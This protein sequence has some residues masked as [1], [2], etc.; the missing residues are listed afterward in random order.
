ME[1]VSTEANFAPLPKRPGKT[2]RPVRKAQALA[3]VLALVSL[4][5]PACNKHEEPEETNTHKIVTTS[6]AAKDVVLTQEYVCQIHSRRHIKIQALQGGYLQ[7]VR[8]KEGQVVKEGDL[9]FKIVPVLYKASLD[10][11]VAEAK[12]AELELKNTERLFA[13]K[14]VSKNEVLLYQA[15]VAKAQAKVAKARAELNFTDVKAPFDGIV[16]RLHDF[17]GSL[18]K[19]GDILTTLSDNGQMWVYF[20]VPEARYLDYMAGQGEGKQSPDIGLMLANGSKYPYSGKITNTGAKFNNE[21]GNTPFRADFPNPKRVLRHGQT[22]VVQIHR[23]VS[24]AIVIPQRA[25]FEILDKRYVW[26][27]GKDDV[28]HQREI[29]VQHE[30]DDIFVIQKGVGVKDRIVLEGVRQVRDGQKLEEQEFRSPDV[31]LAHL[32]HHAE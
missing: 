31:V 15:K 32:K 19:E 11:E 9:M 20:N 2:A 24:G 18:I 12:L 4:A 14:V 26:V 13:D 6:P 8:V 21:T 16:A 29:V 27:I 1:P 28:I 10:A 3:L 22:G 5:L 23:T 30:K 25:T 17:Q 7:E